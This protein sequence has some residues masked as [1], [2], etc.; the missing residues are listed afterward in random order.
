MLITELKPREVFQYFS[1]I[2]AIPH[3]SGNTDKIA[4]YCV[5]FANE[6]GL[7]SI[8]DEYN[9]VVIFAEATSGYEDSKPVMIQGHLD[10][11]CEKDENLALDMEK[12]P[13]KVCTDGNKVWA[14]GTTLGGD[15]GIAVAYILALLAAKDIPHP[16]IEAVLTSDEETGMFGAR[17]LDMTELKAEKLINIDSEE[18]GFLCVSCAGGVRC[19]CRLPYEKRKVESKSE[20]YR[21][22]LGGLQGGHSGVE[23]HKHREN[24]FQ[25]MGSLLSRLMLSCRLT[26]ADI[27]GGGKDNVIP[28]SAEA[29]ICIP[30]DEAALLKQEFESYR[31]LVLE[32]LKLLE[33]D[34]TLKLEKT[35][36]PE[37]TMDESGTRRLVFAL[38]FL[39]NGVER[40]NP[41]IDDLV[42]CSSNL[43]IVNVHEE[44]ITLRSLI[45]SNTRSGKELLLGKV[46]SFIEYLGG[47]VVTESD[48]PAWEYRQTS[49]LREL[50]IREYEAMYG[51]KPVVTAMHAGLECGIFAGKRPELDMISIGPDLVDVHTPQ[52]TMDVKSVERTWEY[53]KR[54][55]AAMN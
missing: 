18:E 39:P 23:I 17:G 28:K 22:S 3:G 12:E 6:H 9:N 2:A 54:V 30:K 15:D 52:E 46:T 38:Q 40:M 31:G 13:V 29:V 48:Y 16:A 19:C 55:L 10:M 21:I 4:D 1:Q 36:L 5:D 20:G 26:L 24:A 7:R 43:G 35:E 44:H 50:M 25:V 27:S 14:K 41:E 8:R 11:V 42:Q 37:F 34:T 49:E 32:E 53:L 47:E 33:P 51:E 45:R